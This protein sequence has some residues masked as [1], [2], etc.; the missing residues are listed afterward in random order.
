MRVLIFGTYDLAS[1][2]R[3]GIIAEGLRAH[4]HEVAECNAPLGLD[5]AARVRMLAQPWR[6]PQLGLRLAGRWATLAR[7]SRRGPKPDV[8]VVGYLGHFDVL[9]ARLLFRTPIILDHLIGAAD[10]ARDRGHGGGAKQVL[11]RAVD[12][13]AL[14]AADIVV[15]DTEEHRETLP[16]KHRPKAVVVPVGAP[17]EWFHHGDHTP[18]EG[19]GSP[20]A[21]TAA[22]DSAAADAAP[23]DTGADTDAGPLKVVFYGLFTPLQG[24]TTI[25]EALDLLR[26]APVEV[27]MIGRGQ[28]HGE[29]VARAAGAP[30]VAWRDW[31]PAAELPAVVAGHDVCLGIFGTGPKAL[32]VVPNKVFQGAAAGCAVVTSDTPPQRRAFGD[33]AVYVPPG[34]AR[35]LADTVRRL[36][37]DRS[38]LREMRA[39]ARE[40]ALHRYVPARVV[41]P[42]VA[43]LPV[44][45]E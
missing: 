11:L 2:P 38:V 16:A 28:D 41:D 9:L 24:T 22:A 6:V 37:D 15:V 45:G 29:A 27:T 7:R 43:R 19:D 5:T 17:Q 12:A 44:R 10:T 32:R 34:D 35:A 26:G 21:D 25:G 31:V 18:S 40:A 20:E 39:R 30:G 4:G 3:V 23:A 33:A 13:A 14:G 1:H 42:L 8:V 36:A